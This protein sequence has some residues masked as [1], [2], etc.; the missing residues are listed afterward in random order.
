MLAQPGELWAPAHAVAELAE[1]LQRKVW[2]GEIQRE[3]RTVAIETTARWLHTAPRA[4]LL[5]AAADISD[6]TSVAIY[7]SLYIALAQA[8]DDTLVTWD[9][10]LLRRIKGTRYAVIVRPLS[11]SWPN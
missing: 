10:R 6:E 8:R 1:I 11:G 4:D 9:L 3:Q 2:K 5:L 7:D